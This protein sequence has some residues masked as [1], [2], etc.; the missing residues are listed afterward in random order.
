MDNLT[1]AQRSRCMSRVR[2]S[3]TD[4]E[5]VVCRALHQRGLRFRKHARALP[6]TPDLVFAAARVAVFVDGDFWHGYRFPSWR[7]SMS[8]FWQA[9]IARNRARDRRNFARLRRQGWTVIRVW[10]HQIRTQLDSA[11]DK[12]ES[13]VH[14]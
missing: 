11:L 14:G 5:T 13:S 4:L 2:T 3:D 12:I 8:P 6:G 9:K 1:R 7:D 10:Q